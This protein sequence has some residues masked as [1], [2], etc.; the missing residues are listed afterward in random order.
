MKSAIEPLPV[1]G[2]SWVIEPRRQSYS[3]RG[4]EVWRY[5]RLVRFFGTRAL[6]KLIRRTYLGWAWAFIRP[7]FPLTV[8][9][10]IFGRVLGIGPE[11]MPYFLFLVVG[12]TSWQLFANSVLWGTRSLELNRGI[13]ARAYVPRLILPIAMMAPAF[14]NFLIY[15]GVAVGTVLYFLVADGQLHVSLGPSLLWAALSAI[16]TVLFALGIA[17]WTSVPAMVARDIRFSLSYVLSFWFFLTPVLYPE[18]TI[19][20]QYRWLL[21]LNPMATLV[22]MFKY[23]VFGTGSLTLPNLAFALVIIAAVLSSGLWF[24]SRKETEAADRV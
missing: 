14:L 9:A 11:G 21:G 7:L 5:R 20:E 17:L 23:G 19:D 15:I 3:A 8:Q 13:L 4:L 12:M 1:P 6:L 16:L 10:V 18:S 22:Q 2:D 24:F